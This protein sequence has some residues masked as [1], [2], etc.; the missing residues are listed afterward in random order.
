M[1]GD[2]RN[3]SL[4]DDLESCHGNNTLGDP[5]ADRTGAWKSKRTKISDNDSNVFLPNISVLIPHKNQHPADD[6]LL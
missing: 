1:E 3:I 4:F 2:S 6:I 5:A